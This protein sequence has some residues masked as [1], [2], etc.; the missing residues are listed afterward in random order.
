MFPET[1]T[2]FRPDEGIYCRKPRPQSAYDCDG[3]LH[4]FVVS[5]PV[6]Y[7]LTRAY[8]IHFLLLWHDIDYLF[9]SAIKHQAN[10]IIA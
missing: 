1:T 4:L 3:L 10:K 6:I 8:V 7:V 9:E 5:L 2:F